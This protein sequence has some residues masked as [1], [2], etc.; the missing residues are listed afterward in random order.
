MNSNTFPILSSDEIREILV[1]RIDQQKQAVGIVVGIIDPTGR[2]IISH[3]KLANND[4]RTLDGDTI[5][6][7][8]SITKVFTSLLLADMV[9]R[10]EVTLDDPASKYLPAHVKLP[11]R[12]SKSITLRDLSMHTSGLPRIPGNLNSKDPANPYAGYGINDLYEFLSSYTLPRDPGAEVEYSNLGG[13]LL[14]HLLEL[15]AGT[16]YETLI[17]ARIT[18]P[19]GMPD[20]AITLSPSMSQ[21]MATGHNML[22]A[23]VPNWDFST[24]AGAGAL[25]SSAKDMLTFLEAFLGYKNSPLAPAMKAMLDVRRPVN[26]TK[27]AVAL[28][29]NLLGDSIWHDGGT[30]GF[31]SL[32][33]YDPKA[34][35]G[36]IVLSNAF[37][38]PGIADIGIHLLNP[39]IA[40]ANPAPPPQRTEIRL[41]P[42]ILDHY[43]G[44]Y[45]WSDR[46]F[47]IT[48]DSGRLFLQVTQAAGQPIAAPKFELFAESE[49]SFFSKVTGSQI[50]FETGPD[51]RATSLT[52][53]RPGREPTLA[54]RL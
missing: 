11:D 5:F 16:D 39:K 7:I 28:G 51:G 38:M 37:A 23:S 21:R 17:R 19:L 13:G 22:L 45:Q 30:G 18:Q 9:N 15:R 35:L 54:P 41:D 49:N 53:R 52:M 20:T 43:T 47:E 6:E 29:W 33:G 25:R 8:G 12:N 10:N 31:C 48:H 2:R 36:V 27:V 3:G 42:A 50:S 34:R 14:G 4:P 40:L 32:A 44:R 26:N 24:L 1:K 46:I